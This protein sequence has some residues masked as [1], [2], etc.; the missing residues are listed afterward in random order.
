MTADPRWK[1]CEGGA[2]RAGRRAL[3]TAIQSAIWTAQKHK[4]AP[5]S[6]RLLIR[7][8]T[9]LAAPACRSHSS[10]RRRVGATLLC[11]HGA[12]LGSARLLPPQPGGQANLEMHG[13]LLRGV[14]T[15][16]GGQVGD[17]PQGC[18]RGGNP[19]S[20]AAQQQHRH[21][22]T[23]ANDTS[24][25]TVGGAGALHL[26]LRSRAPA[27]GPKKV[28]RLDGSPGCFLAVGCAVGL[29][30]LPHGPPNLQR[31]R[32]CWA[33]QGWREQGPWGGVKAGC[34][35]FPARMAREACG[36]SGGFA[37][38]LAAAHRVPC[39]T[40]GQPAASQSKVRTWGRIFRRRPPAVSRVRRAQAGRN[41]FVARAC[42]EEH[43]A[44]CM[45]AA[46]TLSQAHPRLQ[47]CPCYSASPLRQLPPRSL[48][49][50]CHADSQHN[51]AQLRHNNPTQLRH[52]LPRVPPSRPTRAVCLGERM[53]AGQP[54]SRGDVGLM[55]AA[56]VAKILVVCGAVARQRHQAVE[57][58]PASGAGTQA[59]EGAARAHLQGAKGGSSTMQSEEAMESRNGAGAQAGQGAARARLQGQRVREGRPGGS[60][61][62]SVVQLGG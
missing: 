3:H 24:K 61:G 56:L 21:S 10:N 13:H 44:P 4:H 57:A 59:G 39:M 34:K 47:H 6:T 23:K 53:D 17:G 32:A 41:G 5:P 15:G 31:R 38:L 60:L 12:A 19:A 49:T 45:S 8:L 55:P 48:A 30:V 20:T 52:T 18:A 11:V 29:A 36:G 27:L 26:G 22:E 54:H 62:G 35:T 40:T 37:W 1:S 9:I 14:Q 25:R 43:Q 7:L 28:V 2:Q 51:A 50:Q 33:N 46:A 42:T 16:R 58:L